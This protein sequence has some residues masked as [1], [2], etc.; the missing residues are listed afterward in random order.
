MKVGV[1]LGG[2]GLHPLIV[3]GVEHVPEEMGVATTTP[4]GDASCQPVHVGREQIELIFMSRHG[5]QATL[6]PHQINY[7]A[8]VWLMRELGVDALIG[9]HTVGGIDPDLAVGAYVLPHQLIDYTWGRP[10]TYDDQRRHVEFGVPYDADLRQ[11]LLGLVPDIHD[12]GV[13][14]VTQGPRLETAAEIGRMAR[15][16]CTLVGMTGMPEAG[17]ARELEIPYASLC[18]IVNPAAGVGSDEI[19]VQE[20][21]AASEAG[22]VTLTALFAGLLQSQSGG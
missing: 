1:F 2:A 14:G 11:T 18:L 21:R 17:L 13:Y 20:L 3:D 22:A 8:N 19:D 10:S 12:G 4:W 6:A 16:G 15:D 7:R 5:A 9:T